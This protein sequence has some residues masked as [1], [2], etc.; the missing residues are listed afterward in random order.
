MPAAPR[1]QQGFT[2]VEILVVLVIISI[3]VVLAAVRFGQSDVDT[4]QR[5]SER[6]SLLLETARDEAIATGAAAGFSAEPGGYRFWLQQPDASWQPVAESEVLRPRELPQ[7][8]RLANLRVNLQPLPEGGRI[9]FSPSGVN[10]PFSLSLY[11]GAERR[12]LQADALGRITV[13]NPQ[14]QA[15]GAAP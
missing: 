6:L 8:L 2:L 5:E 7:A 14:V 15:A 3:I 1:R 10:A 12:T 9:V 11:A 13:A 4:L